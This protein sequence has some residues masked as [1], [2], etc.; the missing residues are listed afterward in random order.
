MELYVHL[1]YELSRY[2]KDKYV[3]ICGTISQNNFKYT[4]SIYFKLKKYL[5][6]EKL[7]NLKHT[8][9]SNAKIMIDMINTGFSNIFKIEKQLDM[10]IEC[11]YDKK[12]INKLQYIRKI[13]NYYN[14]F[15]IKICINLK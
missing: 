9:I 7:F 4:K 15:N 5:N 14:L 10:D 2:M 13:Y 1:Q 11:I 3:L 12:I 6:I 8:N